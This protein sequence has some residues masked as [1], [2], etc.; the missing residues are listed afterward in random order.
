ISD[1]GILRLSPYIAELLCRSLTDCKALSNLHYLFGGFMD[2][3][4]SCELTS[5]TLAQQTGRTSNA[6]SIPCRFMTNALTWSGFISAF[7]LK[8]ISYNLPFQNML[9]AFMVSEHSTPCA[10]QI[11]SPD[12]KSEYYCLLFQG[13]WA[14]GAAPG[15]KLIWNSTWRIGGRPDRSSRKTFGNSLTTG[16]GYSLKDKNGAKMEISRST[17]QRFPNPPLHSKT[18]PSLPH[19]TW[20][21][22]SLAILKH[23][24]GH[25]QTTR[26]QWLKSQAWAVL[27][28]KG[29]DAFLVLLT[30]E[31]QE[32]QLTRLELPIYKEKTESRETVVNLVVNMAAIG[33]GRQGAGPLPQEEVVD[34]FPTPDYGGVVPTVFSGRGETIAPIAIQATILDLSMTL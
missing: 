34:Q 21:V 23:F 29:Q 31:T 16:T 10:I 32:A 25:Q 22:D 11:V 13:A 17:Q 12:F 5:P 33:A 24:I 18:P 7:R 2:Y 15:I 30:K 19:P 26:D 6:L 4:W 14:T 20:A 9:K 28:S 8:G 1:S 3:L 27:K